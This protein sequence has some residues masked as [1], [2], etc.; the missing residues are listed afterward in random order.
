M[1]R[2]IGAHG[3]SLNPQT[4]KKLAERVRRSAKPGTWSVAVKLARAEA[5]QVESSDDDEIVARVRS[6][7]RAVAPTVVLY[8]GEVEWDCDCGGRMSPCEHVAAASIVLLQG[9]GEATPPEEGAPDE[10]GAPPRPAVPAARPVTRVWG[11][12]IY[13]LMR[14][15]A[16][17]ASRGPS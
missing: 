10:R 11:R 2:Y 7:G 8:P 9:P 14:A 15:E 1:D 12:I 17:C 4:A 6:P 16:G 5:V 3:V 13:R